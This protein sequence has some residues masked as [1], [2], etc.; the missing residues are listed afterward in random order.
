MSRF[1][2]QTKTADLLCKYTYGIVARKPLQAY[3]SYISI[4][5]S[6]QYIGHIS[7]IWYLKGFW[8][9]NEIYGIYMGYVGRYNRD[10][11][12]RIWVRKETYK[13]L[14]EICDKPL[15]D[16][17]DEIIGLLELPDKL[18]D[19]VRRRLLGDSNATVLRYVGS[20]WAIKDELINIA[21]RAPVKKGIFVEVFGGTGI[22]SQYISRKKFRIVVY[23]DI[24]RDLVALHKIVKENPGLLASLLYM[25]PYSRYIRNYMNNMASVEV[26][27]LAGAAILFYLINSSFAGK[28]TSSFATDRSYN[29]ARRFTSKIAALYNT[30]ERFRDVVIE[31]L[32]FKELIEKYDTEE[33]LFYLDPPFISTAG[34]KRDDYYRHGFTARDV[35]RLVNTLR[36]IKGY[37]MMKLSDDNVNYYKDIPIA[38]KVSITKKLDLSL[39]IG[40]ERRTF[41]YMILTNYKLR[42]TEANPP[43]L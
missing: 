10:H 32:D 41:T 18:Y 2:R 31:S 24:D 15:V 3:M 14:I 25:L 17:L 43:T 34:T 26:G 5:C 37:Y 16:C 4:L 12:S 11:Y 36:N 42:D 23:N 35:N 6:W 13:K 19:D 29:I 8:W 1:Y 39:V 21:V 30:S 22:L 20:D 9:F 27:G 7:E 28:L 38:D 33:T 40:K